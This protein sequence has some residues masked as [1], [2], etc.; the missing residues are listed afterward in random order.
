MG[1]LIQRDK[2]K[3]EDE[4][5]NRR[6]VYLLGKGEIAFPVYNESGYVMAW[7]IKPL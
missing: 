4:D 2:T 7:K 1:R 3:T 6:V 5:L